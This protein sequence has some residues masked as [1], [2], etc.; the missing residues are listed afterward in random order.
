MSIAL[1]ILLV[2]LFLYSAYKIYLAWPVIIQQAHQQAD[3]MDDM[4]ILDA[5]RFSLFGYVPTN[6]R[7]HDQDLGNDPLQS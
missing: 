1:V 4:P 6:E 5:A 2:G 3:L 7:D